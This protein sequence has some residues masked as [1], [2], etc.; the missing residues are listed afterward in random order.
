M[1]YQIILNESRLKSFIDWLPELNE[2][3]TYYGCLF[4]R[5][6]YCPEMVYTSDRTQL[7][8]FTANKQNLFNK[9]QQLECKVGTYQLKDR[10]VPQEALVLYIQPNPRNVVKA[11]WDSIDALTK[12][13]RNQSKGYNPHQEV[14]SCIQRATGTKYFVDFDIDTKDVD[15]LLLNNI[16]YDFNVYH[17]VVETRGGYHVLIRAKKA[18][19]AI[20]Y[21]VDWYKAVQNT[22]NI[23][24]NGDQLLPVPGT[25][26]GGFEPKFIEI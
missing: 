17:K 18:S 15:L 9:I 25:H 16:F 10:V 5:K 1:N 20:G 13:L 4:A 8:R 24:K 14:M 3:E 7:K 26:Q 22:F 19:G 2:N 6:K 12:I 11:T 21:P 23:D